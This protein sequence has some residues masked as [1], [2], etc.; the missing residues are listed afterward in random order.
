MKMLLAALLILTGATATFQA[1]TAPAAKPDFSGSWKL[2]VGK[3][4]YGQV[5][6]P[7]SETNIVTQ[8]ED[9]FKVA[10]TQTGQVGDQ[11]YTLTFKAGGADSPMAADAFAANSEFRVL[12]SKAEWVDRVLVVTQKAMYQ[13]GPLEISSRWSLSDD[14]KVI[15]KITGFSLSQGNY[16]TT[17]VSEKN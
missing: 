7:A 10:V 14:G 12:S 6:P 15:T 16:S 9:D 3:S 2:N 8:T 13:G 11:N 4:D 5:P 17:T 1:Q